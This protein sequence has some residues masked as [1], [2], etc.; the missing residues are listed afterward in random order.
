MKSHTTNTFSFIHLAVCLTTSP[1][2][3]PNRPIHTVRS[4]ASSFKCEYPLLT[5]RSS[6]SFLRLLP[7]LSVTSIPPFIFP[8]IT[9]C[10]RQFL[11]KMQ[12]IQLAFRLLTSCRTAF[13]KL[14]SSGDHFYQSEFST[15][16]P[17]LVPFE[18]KL[19]KILNYSVR[20]A[21]H[22]NFI[23]SVFFGLMFN[24]RGPQGQNPRTTVWETLM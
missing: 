18:S 15:D 12:P 6:S 14:F 2:L 22:V 7:R 19:F 9:C 16:R 23:F 21:I 11:R 13:P 20:Y 10:R 8:S 4:K 1:K 5:L 3:L 17:T 24:L